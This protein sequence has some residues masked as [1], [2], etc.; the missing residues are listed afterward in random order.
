MDIIFDDPK[1]EKDCNDQKLLAKNWGTQAPRIRRRLDQ[2]RAAEVLED[3]RNAPGRLHELK[4]NLAGQLSLD[5][6]HPYRLLFEVA[7]HPIPRKAD[8]GL[9]WTQITAIRI[10]K[11][12]DTHD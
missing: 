3:L 2:L 7:N 11:V 6:E 12:K 4:G 10:L 8:G 5:L 1:F 9:D